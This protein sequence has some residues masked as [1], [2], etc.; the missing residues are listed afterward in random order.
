MGYVLNELTNLPIDEGVNFYVF[1]VSDP[2]IDPLTKI[3]EDNFFNLARSL[4]DHAVIAVGTNQER[5]TASVARSYLG[6]NN[7]DTS[8]TSL[9]PALLITNAHPDRL[10]SDSLRLGGALSSTVSSTY[11]RNFMKRPGSKSRDVGRVS[12]RGLGRLLAR[13]PA[14][15]GSTPK[16]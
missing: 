3:I 14:R 1:V 9:L 5:F 16:P 4:G 2:Y 10:N 15:T 7:S 11:R 13:R 8:F 6:K 12:R